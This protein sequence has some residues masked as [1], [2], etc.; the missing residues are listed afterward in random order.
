[1]PENSMSPSGRASRAQLP[2]IQNVRPAPDSAK[3][4]L[5]TAMGRA[6]QSLGAEMLKGL[7]ADP[8]ELAKAKAMIQQVQRASMGAPRANPQDMGPPARPQGPDQMVDP[9]TGMSPSQMASP[10]APR[11]Y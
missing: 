2:G 8:T 10:N 11:I 9:M 4:S 5:F 3:L 1:M 7:E 6:L